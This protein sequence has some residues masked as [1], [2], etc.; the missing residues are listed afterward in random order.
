LFT[1]CPACHTVHP[2]NAAVLTQGRGK[3]RCSK[4]N[5]V[6]NALLALFDDWPKPGEQPSPIG[7]IPLLGQN[8][9]L[10]KAGKTRLNP[11]EA[12]LTGDDEDAPAKKRS[13]SPWLRAL[14]ITGAVVLSV[15]IV[16]KWA[17]FEGQPIQEQPAVQDALI[18]MGLREAPPKKVFRDVS[19]IHLVSRELTENPVEP[20]KLRLSAT[21]V[22]RA[23]R[24][25]PYPDLEVI[26][27]D[28]AGEPVANHRFGPEDYLASYQAGES[29]MSPQAYLPLTLDLEDPGAQAVGF[30]LNFH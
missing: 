26:L 16:F 17:E 11:E 15:A 29:G 6:A 3:Y 22:N 9:D 21:I 14:W 12:G 1:R 28:A 24:E 5:K 18:K 23:P 27:L 2:L 4:C 8:I 7:E 30:E 10:E 19:L 20:G 13:G 25:Q